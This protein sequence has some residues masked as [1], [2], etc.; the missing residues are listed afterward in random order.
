MGTQVAPKAHH[1]DNLDGMGY[2]CLPSVQRPENNRPVVSDGLYDGPR[3]T[4]ESYV[5]DML[6]LRNHSS[7]ASQ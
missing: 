6:C 1:S 4:G 2:G 5:E 3:S 7:R